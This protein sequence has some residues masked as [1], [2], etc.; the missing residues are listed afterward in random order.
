MNKCAAAELD[1][2]APA[3][4]SVIFGQSQ[5]G[6]GCGGIAHE[7][8]D[9]RRRI[10]PFVNRGREPE[11]FGLFLIPYQPTPALFEL[12]I[13]PGNPRLRQDEYDQTCGQPVA[14][15]IL[16]CSIISFPLTEERRRPPV[17]PRPGEREEAPTAVGLLLAQNLIDDRFLACWR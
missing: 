15:Q 8:S 11:S 16:R 9:I 1:D 7:A 5:H 17:S 4:A 12:E 6:E 13:V 2:P 10:P 14:L 3:I